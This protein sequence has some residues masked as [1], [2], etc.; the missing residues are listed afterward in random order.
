VTTAQTTVF[1]ESARATW[2]LLPKAT[3]DDMAARAVLQ[4]AG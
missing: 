4:R 2:S 1:V 3:I